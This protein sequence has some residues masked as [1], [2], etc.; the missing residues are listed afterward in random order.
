VRAVVNSSTSCPLLAETQSDR[1]AAIKVG[2]KCIDVTDAD[3]LPACRAYQ[4]AGLSDAVA[5]Y[6]SDECAGLVAYVS[7]KT[8]CERLDGTTRAE[9]FEDQSGCHSVEGN[10]LPDVCREVQDRVM[11]ANGRSVELYA[12]D[13]CI[14]FVQADITSSSDCDALS[15]SHPRPVAAIKIGASGCLDVPDGAFLPACRAYQ[16]ASLPDAAALYASAECSGLLAYVGT[17]SDCTALGITT[18]VGGIQVGRGACAGVQSAAFVDACREAKGK[19]A[20]GK[21]DSVGLYA[22]DLCIG[23][24]QVVVSSSSDCAALA[25]T[26]TRGVEAIRVGDSPTCVDVED[27]D[28]LGGCLAYQNV[29]NPDALTFYDSDSCDAD[30]RFS[31]VGHQTDCAALARYF[32]QRSVRSIGSGSTC[33]GVAQSDFLT[34]CR[35]FQP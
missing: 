6:Q 34:A 33:Y 35:R 24:V 22:D 4:S 14:G 29:G 5:V 2:A 19:I 13:L 21:G 9:S 1:V 27:M 11:Q 16:S 18:P 28:F 23:N 12:D 7:A 15:K 26:Y 25:K 17:T 10:A 20:Q 32:P 30:H 31:T 3:V 8:K